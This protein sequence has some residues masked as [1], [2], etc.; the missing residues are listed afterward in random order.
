[1][2]RQTENR[3]KNKQMKKVYNITHNNNQCKK[4][5]REKTVRFLKD[6][7]LNKTSISHLKKYT[8]LYC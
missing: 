5:F 1:M 4:T 8:L 3:H 7:P 2:I 6:L